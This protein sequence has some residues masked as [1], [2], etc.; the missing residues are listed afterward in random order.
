MH[1]SPF[2]PERFFEKSLFMRGILFD[3]VEHVWEALSRK[4]PFLKGIFGEIRSDTSLAHIINGELLHIGEGC[5]IGPF[6]VIEGPAWIGNGCLIRPHAYIRA[7]SIIGDGAVIGH[8]TE[9]VRSIIFPKAKLPHFNYVG[10]S[11]IG[12]GANLGAGV[13]CANLRLDGGEISFFHEGKK[14]GTSC[15]K[16]GAIIGNLSLIHI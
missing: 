3:G 12:E 14:Y 10:D 8:S 4:E 13:K 16:L 11:I 6:A 15:K 7:G 1:R 9:I 5:S 2:S